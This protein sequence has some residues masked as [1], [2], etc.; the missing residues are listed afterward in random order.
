MA[1]TTNSYRG[2][3]VRN[4]CFSYS[5]ARCIDDISIDLEPGCFYGLLGPNGSGKSTFLDLLTGHSKP[6]SGSI[7]LN[8]LHLNDYSRNQLSRSLTSVPQS[9]SLNFDYPVYDVVLMGRYPYIDRFSR[10]GRHDHEKVE[11]ALS[12]MGLARFA[13]RS[14]RQLSGGEKQRVMIARSL[15]QDCDY[16]MLD[17]VTANLDINHAISIMKTMTG[18]VRDKGRTVI[19]ALHDLNMALAFCDRALVLKDGRL[20]KSGEV[21]EVISEKMIMELYQVEAKLSGS[22]N[23]QT[24]INYLY[25]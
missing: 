5:R 13:N 12:L 19:A 7:L 23:Q 14:V 16:I 4:L 9:F 20:F 15:A 17:E 18:L 22:A 24:H 8:G 21:N 11:S 3:Q 1:L 25:Q 6:S 2:F 10:P